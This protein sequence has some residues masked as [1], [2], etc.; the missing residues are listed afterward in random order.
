MNNDFSIAA[1]WSDGMDEDGL[2]A[3]ARRLRS[4]LPAKEVSLGLVFMSPKFFLHAQ[5]V[6]EILRVHGQVPLLVG[7]LKCVGRMKQ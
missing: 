7:W 6:L 1:Y 2:A 5:A 4:R 3:W